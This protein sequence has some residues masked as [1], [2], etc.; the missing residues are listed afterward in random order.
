M[1]SIFGILQ[2]LVDVLFT[3]LSYIHEELSLSWGWS[4]VVLTVI[5]RIFLIPLTVRQF[6]SMR[7]MQELQPQIKKLQEK[8]KSDKQTL[9]KKMME[10]YQENEVSPFGSCLPLI[11]QMPVFIALFHM[12][13]TESAVGGAFTTDHAWLWIQNIAQ[14][15]LPLLVLYVA[16]QFGTSSQMS[17][18]D[19][20]QKRMMYMM[21]V[22][23]GVI[24][25]VGRFPAGL[26]IYWLTSNLWTLAQQY[27]IKRAASISKTEAA[28]AGGA[29]GGE[30]S[31]GK[32]GKGGKGSKG[33]G[34]K[35]SKS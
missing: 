1:D 35:G 30:G 17:S 11:L 19:P 22:G 31:K 20:T 23:I 3:V 12:L 10:F 4:I 5:V 7:A 14:F 33:K 27:L 29:S 8:Y 13:R 32:K 34:G 18:T 25:Y 26:F 16:S 28:E 15:D 2:P 24:M 21:P 6:K 9:N